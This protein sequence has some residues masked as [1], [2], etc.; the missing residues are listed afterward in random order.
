MKVNTPQREVFHIASLAG[1]V[2]ASLNPK[3]VTLRL[4]D[5]N[6][7]W[8]FV[9]FTHDEHVKRLGDRE[10]CRL[11]HHE[12]VPFEQTSGCYK[13]HRDMYETTDT[14]QHML[15]ISKLGGNASCA[16]CHGEGPGRK[17]RDTSLACFQCHGDMVVSGSII[18]T[19]EEGLTGFAPGYKDAMHGLCIGCHSKLAATEPARYGKE[20][21]RCD[22]CHR[23]FEDPEHRRMAPYVP[24]PPGHLQ[25]GSPGVGHGMAASVSG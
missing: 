25:V 1:N 8:R 19:K 22:V 18:P 11:C 12:N 9:P 24:M 16:V 15:H 23:D 4:I 10:S 14:F 5:G 2:K 21:A 7:N 6:R 3:P 17:S 20:F 13:C